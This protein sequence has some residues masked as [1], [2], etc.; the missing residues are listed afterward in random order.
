MAK[1]PAQYADR[2]EVVGSRSDPTGAVRRE[3]AAA[4]DTMQVGMVQ[5]VLAPGMQ[6]GQNTDVLGT[7]VPGIGGHLSNGL[8][9]RFEQHSIHQPLVL[10]CQCRDL[11]GQRE[12]EMEVSD[13]QELGLPPLEPLGSRRAWHFGQCRLRHEL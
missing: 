9:S 7:Q 3:P 2:Q 10:Q 6:D 1:Y 8:A 4:H 13:R 5:E 12:D 11:R